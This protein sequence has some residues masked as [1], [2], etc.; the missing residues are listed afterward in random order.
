MA[1]IVHDLTL[2]ALKRLKPLIEQVR[3]QNPS[4]ADQ[5]Q[6][7]GQSTFLNIAEGQ[8]ARGRNEL[9]RFQLALT[10]CR[11]TRAALKLAVA[12]AYVGEAA[13]APAD[14]ELDQV[15]AM[16]WTLVHRP[17]RAM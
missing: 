5:M 15:A 9:A 13:S 11:E 7:A 12:W 6:R 8:S 3:R 16:L 4:L 14:N 17:R 1:F 2:Q 10:E